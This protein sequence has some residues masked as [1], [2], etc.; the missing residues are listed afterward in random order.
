[1]PLINLLGPTYICASECNQHCMTIYIY[2]YIY[3]CVCVYIYIYIYIYIC[4]YIYIYYIY[5]YIYI[6]VITLDHMQ[7][8]NMYED[9]LLIQCLLKLKLKC[10][11]HYMY[12][13]VFI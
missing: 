10:F 7:L 9:I 6:Y 2:I 3:V 4:I 12:I 5:I 13:L 1:M 11:H 8:R